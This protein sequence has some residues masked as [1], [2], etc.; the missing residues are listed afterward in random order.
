MD[1]DEAIRILRQAGLR[2]ANVRQP[3]LT[4][5]ARKTH[6]RPDVPPP[7]YGFERRDGVIRS[8][9]QPDPFRQTAVF[10]RRCDGCFLLVGA[11]SLKDV[12]RLRHW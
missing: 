11:L 8:A 9:V 5:G 1:G 10:E 7:S 3:M 2:S 4:P 12:L 6:Y